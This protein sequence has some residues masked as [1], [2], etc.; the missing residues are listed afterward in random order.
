M[1]APLRRVLVGTPGELG[2]GGEPRGADWRELG[3]LYPP[4][5]RAAREQHAALVARLEEAGAEVLLLPAGTGLSLDAVY[6]HDA[7]LLLDDG[8][9]LLRMGKAAR[10]GEPER[11]GAFYRSLGIPVVGEITPPATA[12]GGDLVW[13]DPRTLLVGRGY[14]T[15]AAGV[16]QLRA[17]LAPRG[18]T[19]LEAPLPHGP[20]PASCI[21]L[22]SFL[23]LLDEETVLVDLPWLAVPVVEELQRRGLRLLEIDPEERAT[24]AANVLALGRRLLALEENPRTNRRLQEAGFQ[25]L[26]F[27][28]GEIAQNGGGGPTCLTRPV[29]R[30]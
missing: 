5:A 29:L 15:N 25:V 14:R 20:G 10:A 23:S 1:V 24:Q 9:L 17:L 8:A 21:H 26:T 18:V 6:P 3:Y 12:E 19:V 16:E 22:M 27:P 13:L 28:G 30:R 2:W 7:S 11:H 4:D